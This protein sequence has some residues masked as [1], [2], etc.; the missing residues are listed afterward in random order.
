MARASAFCESSAG[1]CRALSSVALP[2]ERATPIGAAS[3]YTN[4]ASLRPAALS[5]CGACLKIDLQV[6]YASLERVERVVS[7]HRIGR[8]ARLARTS[9]G[10]ECDAARQCAVVEL[11][12]CDHDRPGGAHAPVEVGF[13]EW[14][15]GVR[16]R[17]PRSVSSGHA[18]HSRCPS[19]VSPREIAARR[20]RQSLSKAPA[21]TSTVFEIT[22]GILSVMPA[23]DRYV[24]SARQRSRRRS[25][26]GASDT[27][28]LAVRQGR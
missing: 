19:A 24:G 1:V 16:R 3:C 6:D 12:A 17:L 14:L 26:A 25:G 8:H 28:R 7:R 5:A 13:V 23:A 11:G 4:A 21:S 9:G 2:A 20:G 18:S 10:L 22:T 15:R 27:A